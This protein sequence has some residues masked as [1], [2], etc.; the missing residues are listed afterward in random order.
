MIYYFEKALGHGQADL[1]SDEQ[2]I[3]AWGHIPGLLVIYTET[4]DGD[5]RVIWEKGKKLVGKEQLE[6]ISD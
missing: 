4:D 3:N 1:G 6:H 5:F 2:A